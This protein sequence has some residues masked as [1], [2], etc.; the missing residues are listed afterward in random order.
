MGYHWL[1]QGLRVLDVDLDDDVMDHDF[2]STGRTIRHFVR[3]Q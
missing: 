1:V 2:V 3:S